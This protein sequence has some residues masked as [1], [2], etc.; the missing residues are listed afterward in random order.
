MKTLAI[1]DI[2]GYETYLYYVLTWLKAVVVK[3]YPMLSKRISLL[4]LSAID[5]QPSDL[6]TFIIAKYII[7]IEVRFESKY[8]VHLAMKISTST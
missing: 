8:N 4:Y 5:N 2:L 7:V 1:C 6:L 3:I